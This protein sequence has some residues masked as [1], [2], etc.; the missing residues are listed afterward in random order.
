MP[1][2]GEASKKRIRS[3][4]ENLQPS[5]K[6]CDPKTDAA[7]PKPEETPFGKRAATGKQ[8]VPPTAPTEAQLKQLE[9]IKRAQEEQN[10]LA[11]K[12]AQAKANKLAAEI[13]EK[14]NPIPA[15]APTPGRSMPTIPDQPTPS[16]SAGTNN[17]DL[18]EQVEAAANF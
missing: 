4:E 10:A 9:I 14:D 18:F 5:K 6:S 16:T 3:P 2:A 11:L 7:A 15:P 17:E 13:A 8:P 1:T 12:A